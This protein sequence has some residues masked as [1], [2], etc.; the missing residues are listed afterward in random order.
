MAYSSDKQH[1]Y[2]ITVDNDL[3]DSLWAEALPLAILFW[4]KLAE[5][6]L[7]SELFRNIAIQML[8]YVQHEITLKIRTR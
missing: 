2:L 4:Q 3:P 1:V 8:H 6:P 7:L 5:Q